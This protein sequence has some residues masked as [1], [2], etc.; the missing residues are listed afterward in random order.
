MA[1]NTSHEVT[2]PNLKLD[3]GQLLNIIRQLDN[4]ARA[5]VAQV[6]LETETDSRFA[7]ALEELSQRLL[8]TDI[9]DL[10][11]DAEIRAVRQARH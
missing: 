5:E 7:H 11:I 4:S 10:D 1:I 9:S 2:I 8:V 6:L 3:L